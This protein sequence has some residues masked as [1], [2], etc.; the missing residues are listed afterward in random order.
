MQPTLNLDAG[1]AAGSLTVQD[2]NALRLISDFGLPARLGLGGPPV[3]LGEG[4]MSLVA[5][6]GVGPRRRISLENGELVAGRL[7]TRL[8]LALDANGA[9][10]VVTGMLAAESLPLPIPDREPLPVALLKGWQANL[11]VTAGRVLGRGATLLRDARATVSLQHGAVSLERIGGRLGGGTLSAS[12]SLD[13]AQ[14]PPA[15]AVQAKLTGA[16]I[17]QAVLAMPIDVTAGKADLSLSLRAAGYS[18]PALSA[19]LSGT[20]QASVRDG[21]L[22]G[23]DLAELRDRLTQSGT[24]P[25]DA[26]LRKPLDGGATPFQ[27]LTLQGEVTHG[28]LSLGTA[29]LTGT[30]GSAEATGSVALPDG[31]ADLR[32]V[33]RPAIPGGPSIP[34][35]VNGALGGPTRTPE[36]A[37]VT[38]WWSGRKH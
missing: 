5:R 8:N 12:A 7:H 15:L 3:W 19:S 13:A 9:E 14:Q 26:S 32:L 27:Q 28:I 16:A 22:S 24:D 18:M 11:Q 2:P 25:S 1:T 35:L 17:E 23:F 34:V 29:S 38:R 37:G 21:T 20:L 10:P 31:T 30:D 33:L 4:S 6:L 36:L